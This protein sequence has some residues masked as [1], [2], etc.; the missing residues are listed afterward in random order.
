MRCWDA[1]SQI[2]DYIDGALDPRVARGVQVHLEKC[3]T[4]PPLYAAIVATTDA[5]H[6]LRGRDPDAVIPPALIHRLAK[7]VD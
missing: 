7:T 4:C 5:L 3:P 6:E 1:R 2:S